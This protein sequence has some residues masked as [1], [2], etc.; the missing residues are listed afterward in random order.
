MDD[1]AGLDERCEVIDFQGESGENEKTM[2]VRNPSSAVG[3]MK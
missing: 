3:I 2:R 1:V